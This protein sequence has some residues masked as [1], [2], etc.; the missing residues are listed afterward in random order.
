VEK[1][2]I[3]PGMILLDLSGSG[4]IEDFASGSATFD[5]LRELGVKLC[6]SEAAPGVTEI[7]RL[8]RVP[9]TLLRLGPTCVKSLPDS[10]EDLRYVQAVMGVAQALSIPV[11][12]RGID[13]QAQLD[14]LRHAGCAYLEGRLLSA[15]LKVVEL[16]ARLTTTQSDP[17]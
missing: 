2:G 14:T 5:R 17:H 16:I 1:I 10:V 3:D 6:A 4:L 11:M 9:L 12:A 15:P 8:A 7:A 13:T